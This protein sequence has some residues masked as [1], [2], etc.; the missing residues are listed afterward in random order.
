[1]NIPILYQRW[2]VF[3]G[4]LIW[5]FTLYGGNNC[6]IIQKLQIHILIKDWWFCKMASRRQLI[7]RFKKSYCTIRMLLFL[8]CILF[9]ASWLVFFLLL[10]WQFNIMLCFTT[11]NMMCKFYLYFMIFT[12]QHFAF[13]LY[14]LLFAPFA[15]LTYTWKYCCQLKINAFTDFDR[16]VFIKIYFCHAWK[17]SH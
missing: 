15:I 7:L 11:T 3:L 9:Y 1:M 16:N 4:L 5:M 6:F 17:K 8:C 12:V 10:F 2:V 13:V 14:F